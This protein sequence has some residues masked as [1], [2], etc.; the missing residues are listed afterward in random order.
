MMIIE[1][2]RGNGMKELKVRRKGRIKNTILFATLAVPPVLLITCLDVWVKH[3]VA[4]L[5]VLGSA[6]VWDVLFG[7]ANSRKRPRAATRS[8]ELG[9]LETDKNFRVY[10]ITSDADLAREEVAS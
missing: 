2:E 1:I 9:N 3:P 10:D 8:Q 5:V 6:S 4:A 7:L